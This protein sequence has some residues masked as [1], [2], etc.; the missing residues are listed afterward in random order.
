LIL[1]KGNS[2]VS[3]KVSSDTSHM[4]FPDRMI[5]QRSVEN[6]QSG[7]PEYEPVNNGETFH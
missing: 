2:L 1:Y 7:A 5:P 3:A 4:H 6:A